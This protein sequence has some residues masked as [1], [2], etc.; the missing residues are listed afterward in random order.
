MELLN[1]MREGWVV[2]IQLTLA[3]LFMQFCSATPADTIIKI[4]T[5]YRRHHYYHHDLH[6]QLLLG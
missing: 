4:N 3:A 5:Y 1:A 6:C 2:F